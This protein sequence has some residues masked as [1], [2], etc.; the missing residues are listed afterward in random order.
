MIY[1]ELISNLCS[2]LNFNTSEFAKKYNTS[3][4]FEIIDNNNIKIFL[5]ETI[6]Q[7]DNFLTVIFKY[8]LDFNVEGLVINI[9]DEVSL[10]GRTL[11]LKFQDGSFLEIKTFEFNNGKL[12]IE[13]LINRYQEV[14]SIYYIDKSLYTNNFE[15]KNTNITNEVELYTTQSLNELNVDK[16]SIYQAL[17]IANIFFIE[18]EDKIESF[19]DLISNRN[20]VYIIPSNNLGSKANNVQSIAV[21]ENNKG[22]DLNLSRVHN[23]FLLAKIQKINNTKI[24]NR[25]SNK[26]LL[27]TLDETIPALIKTT[28]GFIPKNVESCVSYKEDFLYES[29]DSYLI[30]KIDFEFISSISNNDYM[31]DL[32]FIV[33]DVTIKQGIII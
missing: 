33:N 21:S 12:Y 11:L 14:T 26:M 9:V 13:D 5:N 25:I 2:R 19:K 17:G 6:E 7:S 20:S 8:E 18:D 10:N 15:V 29:K 24:N 3:E 30:Y 28:G 31:E 4:R 27:K 22:N 1:Q 32:E 23:F 16:Y